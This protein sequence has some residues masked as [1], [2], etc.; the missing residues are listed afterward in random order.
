MPSKGQRTILP[1]S[2]APGN[3]DA[4]V[5]AAALREV[6]HGQ[7]SAAILGWAAA[8]LQGRAREQPDVIPELG[9]S[10]A[11]LDALLDDF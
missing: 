8:Y 3:P 9:M 4:L 5:V 6:P 2:L 11:E 10:E 1:I 7:R